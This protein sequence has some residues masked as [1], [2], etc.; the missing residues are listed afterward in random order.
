MKPAPPVTRIRIY[1]LLNASGKVARFVEVFFSPERTDTSSPDKK[2]R[3]RTEFRD[4]VLE[5]PAYTSHIHRAA[6]AITRREQYITD[7]TAMLTFTPDESHA[8]RLVS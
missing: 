2:S 1:V 8:I 5:S 3:P 7:T 4:G 6:M